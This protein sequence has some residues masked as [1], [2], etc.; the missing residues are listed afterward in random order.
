MELCGEVVK[1]Q[2]LG[3][4]KIVGFSKDCVTVVFG[5][6][7]TERKFAYPSAFGTFLE[8]ESKPFL[9]QIEKDQKTAANQRAEAAI[10]EEGIQ[11][12]ART[13][14]VAVEKKRAKPKKKE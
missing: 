1:H 5:D 7:L 9:Q 12:H 3:K 10:I 2:A 13:I 11:E 8:V 14:P 6:S 4:G